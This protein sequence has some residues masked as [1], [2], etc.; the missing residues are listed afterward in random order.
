MDTELMGKFAEWREAGLLDSAEFAQLSQLLLGTERSVPEW[1]YK[2]RD[3][4]SLAASGQISRSDFQTIRAQL[5][6]QASKQPDSMHAS[7]AADIESRS[8]LQICTLI[9]CVIGLFPL[10]FAHAPLLIILQ[11]VMLRKICARYGRR[12]GWSLALIILAGVLGPLIFGFFIRFLPFA[13]FILGAL[14]AGAFTWYIG[15]KTRAMCMAGL[16][17]TLRNF[18]KCRLKLK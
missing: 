14:V 3:A 6:E 9:A 13:R 7:E 1:V 2:L 18:F 16:D 5:F 12:P 15:A 4:C 8:V 17:F 11:Y 10:P